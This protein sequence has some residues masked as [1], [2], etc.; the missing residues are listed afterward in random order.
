MK[1]ALERHP[2]IR[3]YADLVTDILID[4][5]AVAGVKTQLGLYFGARS[6]IIATGTFLNGTIHIGDKFIQ[7]GRAGEAPAKGLTAS[8]QALGLPFRRFKTG[9]VPR[10][11]RSTLDLE[12]MRVQPSD[13]RPLRF[14][15]DTV[16]RPQRPLLPCYMTRTTE[17]TH[18]L[19]L[20][21][22][23]RSA[24][25]SGN[26]TGTGPRYCPSF[27]AKIAQFPDKHSHLLFME[28]EGWDTEE[29]Y[30]QG[31]YN[32]MPWEIQV[33]MLKTIPGLEHAHMTRPGY[34]VEYDCID[35]RV[36]D[37][38][39]AYSKVSGLY[40]AGQINGT[41]GYEEAAA[42][43]LIAGVN[44]AHHAVAHDKTLLLSRSEAY[45]GVLID[46]LLT[47]GA[48]EPYR[49]LTSRAEFRILLGQHTAS[50][51]LTSIAQEHH[52]ISHDRVERVAAQRSAID[53][54]KKRLS[55]IYIPAAHP[56]RM[57]LSSSAADRVQPITAIDILRNPSISYDDILMSF[58]TPHPIPVQAAYLLDAEIKS[59]TYTQR[60]LARAT[61]LST[62]EAVRIPSDIDYAALP[63]RS[64][65]VK[66]LS[67]ARPHTLRQ[68]YD[69]FGV[70]AADIASIAAA[71]RNS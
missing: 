2:N 42:Q 51:R 71:I 60:E 22:I 46:D 7:A 54:E 56:L 33:A 67:A 53:A 40:L 30:A 13:A 19:M 4:K 8:L 27:E 43:G 66:Q 58:P 55:A 29:V 17:D 52:L 61:S 39:L 70:T 38:T 59:E 28:Q 48:D 20:A 1:N 63:I 5:G 31:L 24:L 65:A 62:L 69:L 35:P 18:Q 25:H 23:S 15:I 37:P 10:L 45:I 47:K 64:E 26:I 57:M 14:S 11:L 44:A 6:I 50:E 41:S 32:S 36:L 3:I 68:A 49:I 9:T 21:N 12:R 34:A 16:E